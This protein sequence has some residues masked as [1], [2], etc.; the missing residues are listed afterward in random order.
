MKTE[1]RELHTYDGLTTM[2]EFLRKIESVVLEQQRFDALKWALRATLARWWGTHQGNFEDWNECRRRMHL[3][4][5]KP[6]L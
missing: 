6:Q 1:A 5:G 3:R 4:F 2:V